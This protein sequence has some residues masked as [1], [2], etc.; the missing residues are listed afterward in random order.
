MKGRALE[1]LRGQGSWV[2]LWRSVRGVNSD[3]VISNCGRHLAKWGEW[4]SSVAGGEPAPGEKFRLGEPV[5]DRR[6]AA[7]SKGEKGSH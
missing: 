6:R 3:G 4:L 7:A 1:V 5:V 2:L